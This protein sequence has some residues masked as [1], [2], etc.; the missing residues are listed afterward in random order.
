MKV[1]IEQFDDYIDGALSPE[2]ARALERRLAADPAFA[3][4]FEAHKAA[5]DVVVRAGRAQEFRLKIKAG[6]EKEGVFEQF[7]QEQKRSNKWVFATFFLLALLISGSFWALGDRMEERK[8]MQR[9]QQEVALQEANYQHRLDSLATKGKSDEKP[10]SLVEQKIRQL[11]NLDNLPPQIVVWRPTVAELDTL[12][13]ALWLE[14][15]GNVQVAGGPPT[16]ESAFVGRDF[17]LALAI[18]E[19]LPEATV[20]AKERYF[21]GCLR[22]LKTP[23]YA[24][25]AIA[26]LLGATDYRKEGANF[27]LI[28]AYAQNG[29]LKKAKR[30]LPTIS[31]PEQLPKSLLHHLKS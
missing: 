9:L 19:N 28:A 12:I 6:L 1:F 31:R 14:E 11:K 24:E 22:M 13:D 25:K 4:E 16:W 27:Y 20:Y 7:R 5:R 29:E 15:K 30:L 26:D 23:Q 10:D 17:L 21:R 3:A 8:K 2:A 18:L